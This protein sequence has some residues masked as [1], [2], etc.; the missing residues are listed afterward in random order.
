MDLNNF[1][2]ALVASVS[3]VEF[4]SEQKNKLGDKKFQEKMYS[5]FKKYI[6]N[7]KII[8]FAI[9]GNTHTWEISV[10]WELEDEVWFQEAFDFLMSALNKALK[11]NRDQGLRYLEKES[12]KFFRAL[13]TWHENFYLSDFEKIKD[14]KHKVRALFRMLG[15]SIES[16]HKPL[17]EFIY[18]LISI[19]NIFFKNSK[20]FGSKVNDF[21]HNEKL[22]IVY[23]EKLLHVPLSQWR[24]IAQHS[25]YI[26]DANKKNIKCLYG[27]NNEKEINISIDDLYQILSHLNIVQAL[28]KIAIEFLFLEYLEDIDWGEK[29]VNIET[30]CSQIGHALALSSYKIKEI[31]KH[32]KSFVI[33]VI[34]LNCEGILNFKK[35]IF[36]QSSILM[37]MKD[38]GYI[39][40]I[41]LFDID[42]NKLT[43]FREVIV[44]PTSR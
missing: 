38:M 44:L 8:F 37:M 12:P 10:L 14:K 4:I 34:D 2:R 33:N 22:K 19:D 40:Q 36:E 27:N 1:K 15:D 21:I 25:S 30:L 28:H 23:K 17:I 26:Y 9:H 42:G 24:N 5:T 16:T 29:D 6:D 20:S 39:V 18:G 3:D 11:N 32:K 31:K 35:I 41:H 7:E 43:E 13:E